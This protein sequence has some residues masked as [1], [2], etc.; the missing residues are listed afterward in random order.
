[1]KKS[2]KGKA[3]FNILV[4]INNWINNNYSELTDDDIIAEFTKLSR[5]YDI[6]NLDLIIKSTIQQLHQL[7]NGNN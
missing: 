1:M 3:F 4:D 2:P 6:K 5:I 7:Q